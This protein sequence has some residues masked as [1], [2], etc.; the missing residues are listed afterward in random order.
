MKTIIHTLVMFMLFSIPTMAT[1]VYSLV[2]LGTVLTNGGQGHLGYFVGGEMPLKET[3]G[4]QICSR[5]GYF[6]V[7]NAQPEVQGGAVFMVVKQTIATSL[8]DLII[9]IKTGTFIGT[10]EGDDDYRT[11]FGVEFA[12]NAIGNVNVGIGADF[13]PMNDDGDQIFI[14]GMLH[15]DM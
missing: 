1:D 7:N 2:Q 15:L 6:S 5:V 3:K 14:Y 4:F 10:E 9:G 11:A 13:I 8:R 12:L